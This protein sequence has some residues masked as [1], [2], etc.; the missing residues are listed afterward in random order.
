L[1]KTNLKNEIL[2]FVAEKRSRLLPKL[3]QGLWV[4]VQGS[5]NQKV[6][7]SKK[8]KAIIVGCGA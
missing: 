3:S 6:F 8:P 2:K 4:Q 1:I 5:S 7:S